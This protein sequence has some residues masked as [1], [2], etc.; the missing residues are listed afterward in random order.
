MVP[1]PDSF[2]KSV[3]IISILNSKH[4]NILSNFCIDNIR[5]IWLY[6]NIVSNPHNPRI[7]LQ[8]FIKSL[9]KGRRGTGSYLPEQEVRPTNDVAPPTCA[10]V[11][12]RFYFSRCVTSCEGFYGRWMED[13]RGNFRKFKIFG[14]FW[15][16]RFNALT[17]IESLLL[18][19][20][21]H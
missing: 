9:L 4:W 7:Q 6:R 19:A 14:S 20:N 8:T 21:Y 17:I 3:I 5:K 16:T 15:R 2:L 1:E 13:F 10:N 11:L 18:Q 12:A